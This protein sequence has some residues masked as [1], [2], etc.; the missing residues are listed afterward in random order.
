ML[1]PFR[2]HLRAYLAREHSKFFY[3]AVA[4]AP[5][6]LLHCASVATLAGLTSG[7]VAETR[8]EEARSAGQV[9]MG[10]RQLAERRLHESEL[11]LAAL[12]A[13]LKAR[14]QKLSADEDAISQ[15][16]LDGDV[17]AKERDEQTQLV[18]QLRGEL[19]R[20]GGDLHAFAEQK[21]SLER[22]LSVA[23]ARKKRLEQSDAQAAS[24]VR[25]TRDLS[26]L[27]GDGVLSG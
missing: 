21:A 24:L 18:E 5:R 25:A 6:V 16:K 1:S 13:E 17:L 2:K 12:D 8:Y 10:A 14:D 26:A 7:C 20:V 9:E 22:A 3:Q 11:R 23:E 4:Y 27:L 15:S 19:A